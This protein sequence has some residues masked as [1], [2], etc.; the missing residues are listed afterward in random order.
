MAKTGVFRE[1]HLEQLQVFDDG[2]DLFAVE[3]QRLFQLVEDTYEIQHEA[4]WF[5]VR[6]IQPGIGLE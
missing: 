1:E 4:M 6:T 2:I 5:A 3:G